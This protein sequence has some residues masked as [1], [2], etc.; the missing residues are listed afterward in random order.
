M[1]GKATLPSGVIAH[2]L[3]LAADARPTIDGRPQ[4]FQ[5][6]VDL[7]RRDGDGRN[8]VVLL[9]EFVQSVAK[10]GDGAAGGMDLPQQPQRNRAVGLE[11]Q[12]A[13]QVGIGERLD[14]NLVAHVQLVGHRGFLARQAVGHV[15]LIVDAEPILGHVGEPGMADV[16]ALGIGLPGNRPRRFPTAPATVAGGRVHATDV[17]RR[18]GAQRLAQE[19]IMSLLRGNGGNAR[20]RRVGMARPRRSG[21]AHWSDLFPN[22]PSHE[23]RRRQ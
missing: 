13:V 4:V 7:Q 14:A 1:A 19:D 11:D 8:L 22:L 9:V 12:I 6:R 10:L 16:F 21:H 15:E 5:L 20:R 3:A 23:P 18:G 17:A 2:S